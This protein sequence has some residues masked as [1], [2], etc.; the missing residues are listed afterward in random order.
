MFDQAT[1][2]ASSKDM[3]LSHA[4]AALEKLQFEIS[5]FSEE[6]ADAIVTASIVLAG[7]AQDWDQWIVFM[8]GYAM[9]S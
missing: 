3:F 8:E 7:T 1:N 2:S 5:I 9:V 6:N 4:C